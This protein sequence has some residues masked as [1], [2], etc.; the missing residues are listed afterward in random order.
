MNSKPQPVEYSFESLL[1][2]NQPVRQDGCPSLVYLVSLVNS[3]NHGIGETL[4][5]KRILSWLYG[6]EEQAV[7]VEHLRE[8]ERFCDRYFEG[9]FYPQ[10]P[11]MVV[12]RWSPIS[13]ML[14][15]GMEP[16][17]SQ[18]RGKIQSCCYGHLGTESG[19]S[20]PRD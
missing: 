11:C 10:T 1:Y 8:G 9:G 19:C 2:G 12:N 16:A 3:S 20:R 13:A 5:A 7:N 18:S 15:R 6:L 17:D 14:E 4:A